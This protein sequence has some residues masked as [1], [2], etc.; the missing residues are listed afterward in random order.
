MADLIHTGDA[1]RDTASYILRDD[2]GGNVTYAGGSALL[3]G[4]S[5]TDTRAAVSVT[6]GTHTIR[7]FDAGDEP[8]PA[9]G[10]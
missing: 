7:R 2:S 6:P 5:G 8:G 10:T 1:G 3:D 9:P 4:G